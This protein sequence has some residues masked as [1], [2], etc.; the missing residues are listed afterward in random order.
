MSN[1]FNRVKDSVSPPR[2]LSALIRRGAFSQRLAAF[3][4]LAVSQKS[5][6][7]SV[8]NRRSL[9]PRNVRP[10]RRGMAQL[11]VSLRGCIKFPHPLAT[12]FL[13]TSEVLLKEFTQCRP[14]LS[15]TDFSRHPYRCAGRQANFVHP[16]LHQ[17]CVSSQI[18]AK[19]GKTP[20]G[21]IT[22]VFFEVYQFLHYSLLNSS[23]AIQ[24]SFLF[25]QQSF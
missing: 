10:L 5:E 23:R 22:L 21:C 19:C 4:I 18:S 16:D 24:L 3:T 8:Q 9:M 11:R 6:G 2:P 7:T 14:T 12:A 15:K 20:S 25:Y 1:G 17:P 13:Y